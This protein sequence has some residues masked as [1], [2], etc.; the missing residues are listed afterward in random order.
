M[1]VLALLVCAGT[2]VPSDAKRAGPAAPQSVVSLS[3]EAPFARGP[4]GL[5]CSSPPARAF[6]W[7]LSSPCTLFYACRSWSAVKVLSL[8]APS[9]N[10]R[11]ASVSCRCGVSFGSVAC[12]ACW[13]S[14]E[15]VSRH[16]LHK[17]PKSLEGASGFWT[18]SFSKRPC[19]TGS[20]VSHNSLTACWYSS[21]AAS[22]R[23]FAFPFPLPFLGPPPRPGAGGEV[24]QRGEPLG[25]GFGKGG[26]STSWSGAPQAGRRANKMCLFWQTFRK[27]LWKP[28]NPSTAS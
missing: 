25:G 27:T 13:I 17:S 23:A 20:A 1:L 8:C 2:L 19:C 7:P 22:A 12:A 6:A 5:C 15:S 28:S 18:P 10:F 16:M 26:C 14:S 21:L 4:G 9:L 3:G 24:L 11:E